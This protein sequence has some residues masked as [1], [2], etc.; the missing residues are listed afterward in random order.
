LKDHF[1]AWDMKTS[2]D[3]TRSGQFKH[4]PDDLAMAAWIG[5]TKIREMMDREGKMVPQRQVSAAVQQAWG[6]RRLPDS[7]KGSG[8]R[9]VTD[10]IGFWTGDDGGGE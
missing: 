10:V 2:T 9:P 3:R 4:I 5:F 6:T 7:K 1:L 8:Y